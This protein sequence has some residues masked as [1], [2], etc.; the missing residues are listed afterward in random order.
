MKLRLEA[1]DGELARRGPDVLRALA[2]IFDVEAPELSG[3]LEK[4]LPPRE[5]SLKHR[6]LR[7]SHEKWR[8]K[9]RLTLDAMAQEI[10]DLVESKIQKSAPDY[11]Q[12]IYDL[13]EAAY[14]RVRAALAEHGYTDADYEEGGVLY[15]MS[16]NELR[17]VLKDRRRAS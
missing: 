9:Y 4:A 1:E 16:T 11:T 2:Q 6:V 10:A 3:A 12:K 13:D 15:G 14:D 8:R 5:T 7:Q 17:E